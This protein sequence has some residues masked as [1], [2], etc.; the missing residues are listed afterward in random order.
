MSVPHLSRILDAQDKISEALTVCDLIYR[1]SC[2]PHSGNSGFGWATN[3]VAEILM[4]ARE[5]LDF[6]ADELKEGGAA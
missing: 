6:V 4:Q 2:E 1:A 5:E 3:N